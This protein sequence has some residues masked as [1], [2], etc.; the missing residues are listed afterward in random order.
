MT[1]VA[2]EMDSEQV[3]ALS[4]LRRMLVDVD[5]TFSQMLAV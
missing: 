1:T 2:V 4:A 3:G 5:R